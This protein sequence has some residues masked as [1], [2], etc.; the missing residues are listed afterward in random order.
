MV[1]PLSKTHIPD[2][3]PLSLVTPFSIYP[4][5]YC[6]PELLQLG[7]AFSPGPSLTRCRWVNKKFFF[8]FLSTGSLFPARSLF[9][10]RLSCRDLGRRSSPSVPRF[11]YASCFDAPT[12]QKGSGCVPCFIFVI[13]YFFVL[14]F[15]LLLLKMLCSVQFPCF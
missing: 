14:E 3:L 6:F 5:S 7:R 2:P 9:P 11:V 12:P 8:F 10:S 13:P 15:L 4:A 1:F